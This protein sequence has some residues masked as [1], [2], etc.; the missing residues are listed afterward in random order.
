MTLSYHESIFLGPKTFY[1]PFC[2][3][4]IKVRI[5]YSLILIQDFIII[6]YVRI[7]YLKLFLDGYVCDIMYVN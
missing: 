5:K 2:K 6:L 7:D 1:K 4:L 3:R